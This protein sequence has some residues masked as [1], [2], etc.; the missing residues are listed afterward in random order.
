MNVYKT[1]PDYNTHY[2]N[3]MIS[4]L[5]DNS[6][7]FVFENY[8][9]TVENVECSNG[10][11]HITLRFKHGD[12]SWVCFTKHFG[13]IFKYNFL[14]V[15]QQMYSYFSEEFASYYKKRKHNM[16][17]IEFVTSYINLVVITNHWLDIPNNG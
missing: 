14:S 16:A 8:T 4:R 12:F 9:I 10:N 17:D 1:N 6:G 5:T 3:V 2:Y 15:M 7:C 13:P 11:L